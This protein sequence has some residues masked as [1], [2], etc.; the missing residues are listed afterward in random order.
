MLTATV[1]AYPVGVLH[2]K[3]SAQQT[4]THQNLNISPNLPALKPMV[5]IEKKT[6]CKKIDLTNLFYNG[7]RQNL[8]DKTQLIS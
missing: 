4:T 6:N 7:Q 2:N 8:N 5:N 3:A 1:K